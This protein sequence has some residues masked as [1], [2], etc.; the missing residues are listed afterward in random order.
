MIPIRVALITVVTLCPAAFVGDARL[1]AV[2][3]ALTTASAL[4]TLRAHAAKHVAVLPTPL[5]FQPRRSRR[6]AVRPSPPHGM[7]ADR[8]GPSS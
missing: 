1:S 4:V 6:A 5:G 2:R 7:G 3:T 8:A